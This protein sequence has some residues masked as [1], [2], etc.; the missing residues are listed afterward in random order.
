MGTKSR[1][2]FLRIAFATTAVT[3]LTACGGTSAPSS[4]TP[5]PTA[6][7]GA[8][9]TS[10]QSPSPTK[11]AVAN[12]PSSKGPVT[13]ELIAADWVIQEWKLPDWVKK[14]NDLG[15]NKINLTQTT[16]G[17][18]TKVLAMIRQG[19]VLWDGVGIMTP[20][21]DKVKWV[22]TGMIQPVDA[23]IQSSTADDAK[24]I[25][26][27]W[28]PTIKD[29]ISYKGKV[30]GVPYSVEAIGQMWLTEFLDGIG[31]K[32]NPATWSE[33]LDAAT[34][35]REKYQSQ[36]V[37]AYA[38][39]NGLHTSLQALIH[40]GS[41]T[42]YTS[43]GLLDITGEVSLKACEWMINLVKNGLTPPHGSDGAIDIWQKRKLALLLAQNSRGVWAQRIFGMAAAG[44]GTVPLME[45]GGA[46]SGS[47]FWSN[48]FVVFNKAK[49]PQELV[50]FYIWLLGP[51]NKDVWQAI[52]AS[53]KAPV[54]DSIYKSMIENSADYKWM[55]DFRDVIANS[56]PYPEN[57]YWEIQ[58]AKIMPWISKMVSPPFNLSPQ[59]AMESAL[60]DVQAEVAK[61]KVK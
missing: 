61:Q 39:V 14:Y 40:S 17:W 12:Q 35:I 32:A 55:A 4:S 47:P 58:N 46:N 16:D 6:A 44:T 54:L 18:D 48:T 27:D 28:L 24:R 19:D 9:Q 22:E 29:D 10:Q 8:P 13:V 53:G 38:W 41:K 59:Q 5:A 23:F 45:K 3:L 30:Y 49:H 37:T 15:G 52:I 57:T 43:D 33:T 51:S 25:M 11:P 2:D 1:R 20:F 31:L 50:D 21:I 36:Q 34:K 56:V 7:G 42:P 60:K 26:S